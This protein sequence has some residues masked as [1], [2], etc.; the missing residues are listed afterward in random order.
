LCL[1]TFKSDK[2]ARFHRLIKHNNCSTCNWTVVT[3]KQRHLERCDKKIYRD[4][5]FEDSLD[6]KEMLLNTLKTCPLPIKWILNRKIK[7]VKYTN[8]ESGNLVEDAKSK[9]IFSSSITLTCNQSEVLEQLDNNISKILES[10]DSFQREGSGWVYLNTDHWLLKV[11]KYVPLAPSSYIPTPSKLIGKRAIINI[12]NPSDNKCFMWSIL[13][14]LHTPKSDGNLVSKYVDY[15]HELNMTGISYP[16]DIKQVSRFEQQNDISVNIFGYSH[17]K[18]KVFPLRI[19]PNMQ[20]IH[21]NLLVLTKG[22]VK[23]YTLIAHFDRLLSKINKH[24]HKKYFCY[25]CLQPL[26]S[27]FKL[28]KHIQ[29]CQTHGCQRTEFP[30]YKTLQFKNHSFE[31]KIPYVIYGDFECFITENNEHIPSGYCLIVI[32][33]KSEIMRTVTYSGVNVMDSFFKDLFNFESLIEELNDVNIPLIMTETDQIAFDNATVCHICR[34]PLNN[35]KVVRDHDH[36]TGKFRGASHNECNLNY[37]VSNKIPVI[38]HNSRNY[39]SHL[40]MQELGKY[41]H[42]RR[43][44]VIGK[45]TEKYIT[46]S[47]GNLQFL[48]SYNFLSASLS[49][50]VKT[51]KTFRYVKQELLKKKGVYPYEY[52]QSRDR[53]N[54]KLPSIEHFYSSLKGKD[55]SPEKYE[56]ALTVW[57]YFN[58]KNMQQYHDLYLETDTKLLAEVFETFRE[59]SLRDYGIDPCNV[60]SLPGLTWQAA[61]KFTGEEI[62]LIRNSTMHLFIEEGI[63]GGVSMISTKYSKANNKYMGDYDPT[64][65]S[66]YIIYLDCNA[67]YSTAMMEKLPHSNFKWCTYQ[68]YLDNTDENIGHIL[69]VDLEYPKSLH[70]I[71]N[72]YPLAPERMHGK[73]I[74]N[75]YNKRN[76]ILHYSALQ[77]YVELGMKVVNVHKV[78]Q[79]NQKAWLKPYIEFNINKRMNALNDFE[80]KFYK[81]L[82]NSLFGKTI[83]NQRKYNSIKLVLE[84]KLEKYVTNPAIKDSKKNREQ[85]PR[86]SLTKASYCTK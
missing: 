6:V 68:Q 71:H 62:D 43:I 78:L 11:Y 22:K 84:D 31:L 32:N 38:F 59:I 53:F 47:I 85:S 75:L 40:I 50:L 19:T 23:H 21:V 65:E 69:Q 57:K 45:D 83:E 8:D 72:D 15:E 51:L 26:Y 54:E 86:C 76:Y 7:F 74:P 60:F 35:T 12:R 48:D 10:I 16:V 67:L 41:I 66:K 24:Q 56:H 58:I 29:L 39:D 79:F 52:M 82:L 73:L 42:D 80:K 18:N 70:D 14:A 28:N 81:D 46:F 1:E 9:P 77:K 5:K 61:L 13:A 4:F 36:R 37:Q 30:F 34:K 49:K 33:D 25:Y 3:N 44:T 55:I 2:D 17:T 27:Q 63:R 64:K 20:F